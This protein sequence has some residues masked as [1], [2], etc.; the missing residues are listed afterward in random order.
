[1]RIWILAFAITGALATF[2]TQAEPGPS[3]TAETLAARNAQAR[4]GLESLRAIT[5]LKR[6]GKLL[7]NGGSFR[8][9]YVQMQKRGAPKD[10]IAVPMIR[11]EASLQGLTVI[12]AWDGT[13]GW[14]INP[15]QGRK[16]P[17][18]TPP[19]DS[20]SLI[21][22][23]DIDGP[24]ID[25]QARHYTLD[26]LG[27]ED[28]D[29]TPALKLKVSKPGGDVILVFLD[30]DYFLE[31]R[32]IS[33]RTEHGVPL[34][35]Q[36]DYG[37]YEKVAGVYF[38]FSIVSGKKGSTD[39]QKIQFDRGEANIEIRDAKFHFPAPGVTVGPITESEDQK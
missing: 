39:T 11:D 23:A 14:Q 8:L 25:W 34:E 6:S 35:T 33:Q 19:D 2:S 13:E 32:T 24:L 5:T 22:D 12:Q 28:V 37:D 1:M 15:F 16:D 9:D 36:A 38:P 31:I 10:G 18:R 26:Y 30:P 3:W 7:V 4:G 20:K 27:T 21:E 29:G 17:E